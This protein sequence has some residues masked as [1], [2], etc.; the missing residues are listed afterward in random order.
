MY[1]TAQHIRNRDGLEEVHAF[2]H[3]H[4]RPDC[5]FPQ[6]DPLS[7]PERNPGRLVAR[8]PSMIHPGGNNVLAY[9]D[10]IAHDRLWAMA[11]EMSGIAAVADFMEDRPPPWVATVG[12]VHVVFNAT[13]GL[14]VGG[15]YR[16]LLDA[17][18][19]LWRAHTHE[20]VSG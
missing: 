5:A 3:L 20:E 19:R 11:S 7:V 14:G 6:D 12:F 16:T 4:D 10:L 13:E 1:L 18:H 2:L 17:A 15:E 9:L 8:L